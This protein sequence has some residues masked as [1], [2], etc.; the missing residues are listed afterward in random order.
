VC[1]HFAVYHTFNS[2]ALNAPNS[3]FRAMKTAASCC[4]CFRRHGNEVS[5]QD[6]LKSICMFSFSI[7]L[8]D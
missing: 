5:L 4:C 7:N 2:A 1:R 6:L 3:N 8:F